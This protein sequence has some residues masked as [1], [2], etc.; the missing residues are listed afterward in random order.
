LNAAN[1][2]SL[3][4]GKNGIRLMVTGDDGLPVFD[5]GKAT[6]GTSTT[7]QITSLVGSS[8]PYLGNTYTNFSK[9]ITIGSPNYSSSNTS[10]VS[11]ITLIQGTAGG[12]AINE[13][14]NSRPEFLSALFNSSGISYSKRVSSTT[15]STNLYVAQRLGIT[16]EDNLG[17]IR[18]NVPV[19]EA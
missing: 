12:N 14:H 17:A 10:T 13:N 9:K 7:N 11:G 15:L 3:S 18:L 1:P 5:S 2:T 4:T 8:A 16:S 19:T 6:S